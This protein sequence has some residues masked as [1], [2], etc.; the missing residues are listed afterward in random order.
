MEMESDFELMSRL[1]EHNPLR[2]VGLVRSLVIKP[3]KPKIAVIISPT[4]ESPISLNKI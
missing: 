4:V 2:R 3:A 1:D